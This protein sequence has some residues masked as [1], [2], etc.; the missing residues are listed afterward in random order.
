MEPVTEAELIRAFCEEAEHVVLPDLNGLPWPEMDYLGW[1]HPSGRL[2]YLALV[3]P[4]TGA[5][6]GSVLTRSGMRST[7]P[8][9][10][11]CSW[12]RHVHNRN[13]TAMFSVSVKGTRG[14]HR[15]GQVLCKDLD[16]SLRLRNLIEPRSYM[17]ETLY[18]E[19]RV[20]RM[21]MS[22]HRWLRKAN[23]L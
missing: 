22:I 21:Q 9:L 3:S 7:R 17:G 2:G 5:L 14:R 11:M 18:L 6:T 8:R 4:E 23:R 15:L 19:A 13:G 20:W 1:V 10:E 12:C 16:C